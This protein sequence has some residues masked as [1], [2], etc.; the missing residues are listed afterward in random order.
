[1]T[2]AA[3][4]GS[5]GRSYT[6]PM[7]RLPTLALLLEGQTIRL[8]RGDSW[9]VP[10]GAKHTYLI[11]EPFTAVEATAPPSQ[12]HGRDEPRELVEPPG[13]GLLVLVAVTLGEL[14]DGLLFT[15]CVEPFGT[16]G[17]CI[18][19]GE[20]EPDPV[21]EHHLARVGDRAV[22]VSEVGL[23]PGDPTVHVGAGLTGDRPEGDPVLARC[24]IDRPEPVGRA[25]S[26]VRQGL[27]VDDLGLR[28]VN[29]RQQGQHRGE[30]PGERK[31]QATLIR[32]C[33]T[34]SRHRP[35]PVSLG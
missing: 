27:R 12:V 18:L 21:V 34:T 6:R 13:V 10:A 14:G 4:R 17:C 30:K 7:R 33:T 26:A 23:D 24:D 31:H 11:L 15:C 3:T 32:S 35:S 25:L 29:R 5:E 9:L 28:L 22:G 2:A 20:V 1:M 16:A 8:E 19:T